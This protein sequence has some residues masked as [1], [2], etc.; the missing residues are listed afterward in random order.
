MKIFAPYLNALLKYAQYQNMDGDSLKNILTGL[1]INLHNQDDMINAND[2][3]TVLKS[4]IETTENEHTGL[5]L[6]TYFNLGA[7][8]LV[9]EISLSTSSIQQGVFILQSFL[10][11]KFP[12]VSATVI[13]DPEHYILQLDCPI[14]DHLLRQ[15]ILDMVLCIIYRELSLMLPNTYKPK[16]RLPVIAPKPY[17]DVLNVDVSFHTNY[18]FLLPSHIVSA[19]INKN[20]I[21]EIEFLLPKFIAMLNEIKDSDTIFSAQIRKMILNM[22]APEIPSFEQVQQ[23]FFYSKRTIQRKLTQE[24]MSFRSIVNDIKKELSFYLSHEKH[25][26]T[27]DIAYILGYSGSSAYLHAVKAWE[28]FS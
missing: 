26:K 23:Q 13:D 6:G 16:I 14:K 15:N 19:E 17:N 20:K 28:K 8:G 10:E 12:L 2:Y 24:G 3:L 18:Q 11:T 25:L 7:L 9:L 1:D 21:K 5:N 22:C 4:I 27:Q